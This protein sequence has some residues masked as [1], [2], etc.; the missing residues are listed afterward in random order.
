M[1]ID[2]KLEKIEAMLLILVERQK[3]REWYSVDEFAQT[4]GRSEFTCRE[5]CRNGRIKAEKKH[6]GRGAH[7]ARGSSPMKSCNATGAKGCCEIAKPAGSATPAFTQEVSMFME[8][9]GG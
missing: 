4:V 6:S 7:T 5:W 2:E 9:P 8:E 1:T 3:V